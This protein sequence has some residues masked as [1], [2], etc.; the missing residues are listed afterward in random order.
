M[1]AD[2]EFRNVGSNARYHPRALVTQY[3]GQR[4]R[5]VLMDDGEVGMAYA[6]ASQL[7]QN[8]ACPDRRQVQRLYREWRILATSQRRLDLHEFETIRALSER[9]PRKARLVCQSSVSRI[10]MPWNRENTA[11]KNSSCCILA[12]N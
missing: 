4:Q 1:I 3:V 8:L 7:H 9:R 5:K 11:V 2:L 10:S 6:G 12:T